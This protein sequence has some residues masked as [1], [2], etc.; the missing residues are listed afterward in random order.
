MKNVTKLMTGIALLSVVPSVLS[1]QQAGQTTLYKDMAP[2]SVQEMASIQPL[3]D[4]EHI[5]GCGCEACQQ[6]FVAKDI[7]A[8]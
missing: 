4:Q 2:Y 8:V 6:S 1:A 7:S 5:S 3:A